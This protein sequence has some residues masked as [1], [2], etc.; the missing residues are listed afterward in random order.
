MSDDD[1]ISLDAY[2]IKARG[3]CSHYGQ[4]R[5]LD[6]AS[7]KI[8][9]KACNQELDA[10]ECMLEMTKHYDRVTSRLQEI[11][12]K[13]KEAHERLEEVLRVERNARS[14]VKRLEATP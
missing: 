14:R 4:T 1:P 8:T 7:R 9:C 6:A 10:F 2:R 13:T 5:M 3:T 11:E 12:R